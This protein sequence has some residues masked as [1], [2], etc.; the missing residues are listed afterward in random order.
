MNDKPPS[1]VRSEH[2]NDADG[3]PAGGITEARGF[4]ISWQNGAF[5]EYVIWAAIDRLEYYQRGPFECYENEEALYCLRGAIGALNKRR[6]RRKDL[7]IENTH[8]PHDTHPDL[9]E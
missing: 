6:Q 2:W 4:T 1:G 7:G 3:N 8:I 5:L 9:R